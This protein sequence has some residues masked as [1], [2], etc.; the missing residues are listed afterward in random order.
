MVSFAEISDMGSIPFWGI[1][2]VVIGMLGGSVAVVIDSTAKWTRAI[3]QL[4]SVQEELVEQK[5]ANAA[6]FDTIQRQLD[7]LACRIV[8]PGTCVNNKPFNR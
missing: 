3:E 4:K 2:L 8:A 7:Y 5:K 1:V 6:G